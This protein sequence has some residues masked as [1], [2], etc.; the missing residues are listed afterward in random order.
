MNQLLSP[1][2]FILDPST[3]SDQSLDEVGL[4]ESRRA[5]DRWKLLK[6][7]T[8]FGISVREESQFSR[9]PKGLNHLTRRNA[10]KNLKVGTTRSS[11]DDLSSGGG[12]HFHRN[13]A[14]ER[15]VS[16]ASQLSSVSGFSD[17]GYAA[18]G[19]AV[20]TSGDHDD[21]SSEVRTFI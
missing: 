4:L 21:E 5:Q 3:S 9:N 10:V 12:G 16:N 19:G 2:C 18:I 11:A 20:D 6:N 14:V 17:D 15:V 13:F 1:I 7:I 8:K